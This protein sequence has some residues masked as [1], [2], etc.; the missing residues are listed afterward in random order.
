SRLGRAA[1]RRPWRQRV[2]G[3]DVWPI[4]PGYEVLGVLGRGG[5]GV[6]YRARQTD[7]KRLVALKTILTGPQADAEE[8][9]RF[10]TEAEAVARLQHP[11]IVQIFEVGEGRMG[12]AGPV[13]PYFAMELVEGGS[14]ADRLRG[15]PLSPGDAVALVETLARAVYVAHQAGI[16]H[17]DL[18]PANVLLARNPKSQEPNHKQIP[19]SKDPNPKLAS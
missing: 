3:D 8:R 14:L 2:H 11:N 15:S 10:Q 1:A 7:L 4:V 19:N 18:K 9:T 16:V 6:V 5:M 17:R 12:D 13:V